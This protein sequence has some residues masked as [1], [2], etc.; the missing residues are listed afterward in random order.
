VVG[1]SVGDNIKKTPGKCLK[2]VMEKYF[3]SYDEKI[4]FSAD[5]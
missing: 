2:P 1:R 5:A 3:V 4:K